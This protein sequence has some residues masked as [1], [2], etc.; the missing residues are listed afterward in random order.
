MRA[1]P[2]QYKRVLSARADEAPVK[3][4]RGKY[5]YHVLL[6]LFEHADAKPVLDLLSDLA[7][8]SD[9]ECQVYYELNPSTLL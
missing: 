1:H 3:M 9:E 5:R 4:I 6:K 2:A 7:L 8:I